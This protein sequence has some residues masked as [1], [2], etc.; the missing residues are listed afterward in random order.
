MA[1]P[2][3]RLRSE[4]R[5][6]ARELLGRYNAQREPEAPKLKLRDIWPLFITLCDSRGNFYTPKTKNPLQ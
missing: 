2:R 3:S 6:M 1:H 4:R 5:K